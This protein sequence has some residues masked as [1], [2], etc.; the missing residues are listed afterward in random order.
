MTGGGDRGGTPLRQSLHLQEST[1]IQGNI[2]AGFN[3]PRQA[4]VFLRFAGA[5]GKEATANARRWL[6]RLTAPAA[7]RVT[8]TG[9]VTAFRKARQ[10]NPGLT[11]VWL[12]VGLT[13]SGLLTLHPELASDVARFTAF[14]RGPTG[15]RAD[16]AR[17]DGGREVLWSLDGRR[18]APVDAQDWRT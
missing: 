1:T 11:S 3:K 2:V 7:D 8:S 5:D 4:F 9:E 12:N 16:V 15:T 10:E 6:T 13:C 17:R 14:S 18:P